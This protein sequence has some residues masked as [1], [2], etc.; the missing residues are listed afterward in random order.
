MGKPGF[1]VTPGA[2]VW[3][4]SLGGAGGRLPWRYL[5]A[6]HIRPGETKVLCMGAAI[7]VL[8][9]GAEEGLVGFLTDLAQLVGGPALEAT[10]QLITTRCGF[11]ERL[12]AHDAAVGGGCGAAL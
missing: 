4:S 10:R 8:G 2:L 11:C 1:V 9:G 6:E 12:N 5:S 7:G 3:A